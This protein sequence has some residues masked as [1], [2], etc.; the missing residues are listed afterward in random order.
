MVV[1]KTWRLG[2]MFNNIN[3]N[4]SFYQAQLESQTNIVNLALMRANA[5]KQSSANNKNPYV[6]K[7]E[8]SSN[9]IELFQKDC[10]IKKFNKIAL[11]DADDFSHLELMK[12]LFSNGVVDAYEDDVMAELADNLKLWNDLEL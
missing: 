12:E 2:S 4:D 5:A 3:D 8:I 11:S 9:A 1:E 7:T 10:D 6:D